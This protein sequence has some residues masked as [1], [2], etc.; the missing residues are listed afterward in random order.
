MRRAALRLSAAAGLVLALAAPAY[1]AWNAGGT[2]Q[3]STRADTLPKGPTPTATTPIGRDVQVTWD[4]VPF[5]GSSLLRTFTGGGYQLTRNGVAVGSPCVNLPAAATAT[6]ATCIDTGVTPGS[7]TYQ[8]VPQLGSWSGAAGTPVTVTVPEP[9]LT[10]PTSAAWTSPST[11]LMGTVQGFLDQATMVYR[12]DDPMTGAVITSGLSPFPTNPTT[13]QNTS[14]LVGCGPSSSNAHTVYVASD[15]APATSTFTGNFANV[16]CPSAVTST[17]GSVARQA[18]PNDTFSITWSRAVDGTTIC[19]DLTGSGTTSLANNLTVSIEDGTGSTADQLVVRAP[20][21]TALLAL[22]A[23]GACG[24]K[25]PLLAGLLGTD[26]VV[27]LGSISLG[28]PDYVSGAPLVFA[29]SGT[30]RSYLSLTNNVLTVTLGSLA[31]GGTAATAA[32][33]SVATFT[34]SSTIK[35]A[36]G[37]LNA[38]GFQGSGAPLF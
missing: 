20:A 36:S 28:S 21:G 7:T 32:A 37:N 13:T 15:R 22:G 6:S 9:T 5:H 25:A 19:K 38:Q 23:T 11:A 17:V 10:L 35:S 1:A 30:N 33:G 14:L 12:L 27:N 34:P 24:T 26:G 18:Q 29:G 31:S 8:V 16:L 4:Q 2:G 3:G